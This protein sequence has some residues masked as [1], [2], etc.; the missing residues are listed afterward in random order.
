MRAL[1]KT[2]AFLV[3]VLALLG[4]AYLAHLAHLAQSPLATVACGG[5]GWGLGMLAS[6]VGEL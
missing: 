2:V 1:I 6:A 4:V 3:L 5:F